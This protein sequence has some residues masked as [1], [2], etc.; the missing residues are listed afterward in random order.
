MIC[1]TKEEMKSLRRQFPRIQATRTVHKYYVAET[2]AVVKF[3][4]E[5]FGRRESK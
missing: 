5:R 4:N 1:I 2:P 3:L